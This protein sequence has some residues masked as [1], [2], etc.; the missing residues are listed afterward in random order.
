MLISFS[1]V[2]NESKPAEFCYSNVFVW[3]SR[4][5]GLDERIRLE[6]AAIDGL[7]NLL[8]SLDGLRLGHT[9]NSPLKTNCHSKRSALLHGKLD[10]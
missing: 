3:I 9:R 2:D 4:V 7:S 10:C 5:L 6:S 8:S 1:V